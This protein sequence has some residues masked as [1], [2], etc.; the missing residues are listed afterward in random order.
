[1]AVSVR[2]V[3]DHKNKYH[4]LQP[5]KAPFNLQFVALFIHKQDCER[6]TTRGAGLSASWSASVRPR[7]L[8]ESILH[9]IGCLSMVAGVKKNCVAE[10]QALSP[11]SMGIIAFQA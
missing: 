3:I 9:V 2:T 8:L 5:E 6:S 4:S 7:R 10:P 1:M 11:G